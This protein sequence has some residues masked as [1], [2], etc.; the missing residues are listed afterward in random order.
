MQSSIR[1]EE[2]SYQE[3]LMRSMGP[4][5][6]SINTPGNDCTPCAMDVP[7]DPYSRYQRYGSATCP[8]GT[9][10]NDESELKGL[11]Y[12]NTNCS[13]KKYMPGNYKST[14]CVING[15]AP[16]CGNTT[17]DTRLSNN[18]C[19]LRGTGINRFIPYF[20]GCNRN[21]QDYLAIEEFNH[22]P[23]N[24]KEL[25]KQNHVPCIENIDDQSK[26]L[27]PT[28]NNNFD[29]SYKPVPMEP[30]PANLYLFGQAPKSCN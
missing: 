14:G 26:F 10:T 28:T 18:A 25:F 22:V 12:K 19:N 6:Y 3:Q 2:C 4:G 21:P 16:S 8:P 1:Q 15:T 9:S 13:S 17:E 24:V 27:P 7:P 23:T 29:P 30:N 11:N 5:L 20:A